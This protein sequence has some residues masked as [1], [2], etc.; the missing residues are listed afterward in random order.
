MKTHTPKLHVSVRTMDTLDTLDFASLDDDDG[1]D[2][3]ISASQQ[4]T[5]FKVDNAVDADGD[6]GRSPTIPSSPTQI[7]A[8]ASSRQNLNSVCALAPVAQFL[9]FLDFFFLCF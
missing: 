7:R 4:A 5:I 8:R 1:D 3:E 9:C 2:L 6:E